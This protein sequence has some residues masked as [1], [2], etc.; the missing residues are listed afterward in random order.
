MKI[1]L[2]IKDEKDAENIF[3]FFFQT[4]L[5]FSPDIS[6]STNG[7]DKSGIL[8]NN[9]TTDKN[10]IYFDCFNRKKNSRWN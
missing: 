7:N 4:V 1:F 9:T 10:H 5:G 6:K 2:T 3:G 8:A